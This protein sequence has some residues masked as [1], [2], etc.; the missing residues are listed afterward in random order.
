MTQN[1]KP[2]LLHEYYLM[3]QE[4]FGDGRFCCHLSLFYKE[5]RNGLQQKKKSFI[6]YSEL[7]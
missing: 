2:C 5:I 7:L 6:P 1:L 4:I 3:A